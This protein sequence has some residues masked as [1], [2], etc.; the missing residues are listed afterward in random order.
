MIMIAKIATIAA[1]PADGVDLLFRDLAQRFAVASHRG[2]QDHEVLHGAAEHDADDEP[3]RAG[4]E[5]EL[6]GERRADQRAGAGDGREVVAED[7]P[8]RCRHEIAA[9]VQAARPACARRASSPKTVSRDESRIEPIGD[10][11]RTDGGHHQPRGADRSRRGP[12]R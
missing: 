7:H 11:V 10:G 8:L 3:E 6:R 1:M 5:A 4:Q 2:A 9:V 12:G